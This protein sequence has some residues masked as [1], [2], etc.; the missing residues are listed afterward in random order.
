MKPY[1]GQRFPPKAGVYAVRA[2]PIIAQ[3]V[4]FFLKEEPLIPYVPQREFLALM[5]TGDSKAIGS[6]HGITFAGKW[7]WEM[8]DYIDSGFMKLFDPHYLFKDFDGQGTSC[9]LENNELFD[10]EKKEIEG[11]LGP[12]RAKV[13]NMTPEDAAKIIGCDEEEM[14]FHERL[15]ILTRMANEKDF[16]DAVVSSFNPS[17]Y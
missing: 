15:T 14:E 9:P 2:G 12:I 13:G 5:M 1:E 3:N 16:C 11:V 17:Y 8:K 10:D 4:A 7:V 6:K